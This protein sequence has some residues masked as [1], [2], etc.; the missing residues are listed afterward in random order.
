MIYRASNS[1]ASSVALNSAAYLGS[2]LLVHE[3][4]EELLSVQ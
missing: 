1:A 3:G 2:L 4:A